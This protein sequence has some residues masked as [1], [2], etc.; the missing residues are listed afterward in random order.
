M[1]PSTDWSSLQGALGVPLP[2]STQWDI[3]EKAATPAHPAYKELI[4]QAA[5]GEIIHNDDTTMKILADVNE[6][7]ERAPSP[8]GCSPSPARRRSPFSLPAGHAGE[9]LADL[10]A[11][12]H[13]GLDLPIQMCDALSRNEPKEFATFLANCLAHARR[14][15]VDVAESFPEECRHVIELFA[16]VYE[17]DAKAKK[18]RCRPR[19]GLSTI[20]RKAVRLWRTSVNG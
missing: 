15:F 18:R 19:R 10:L 17:H 5:Q 3:V 14:N 9:N 20:R 1:F 11:E 16:K 13:E 8:R 6:G 7:E 2:A 4:R 12:R